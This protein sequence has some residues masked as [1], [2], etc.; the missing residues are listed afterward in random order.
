M[1]RYLEDRVHTFCTRIDLLR[2]FDVER[3]QAHA[4]KKGKTEAKT[5]KGGD[6]CVSLDLYP[7]N[8]ELGEGEKPRRAGDA[9][10]AGGLG[11]GGPS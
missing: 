7:L 3:S 9:S 1:Y 8:S 6:S 10:R 4:R 11:T 5:S 2:C